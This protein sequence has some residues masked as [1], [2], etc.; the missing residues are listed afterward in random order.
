MGEDPSSGGGGVAGT[1]CNCEACTE[2]RKIECE[3]EKE[4]QELQQCWMELRHVVRCVYREAGTGMGAGGEEKRAEENT[5]SSLQV[6]DTNK[7]KD[8]VHR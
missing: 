7:M 2:R 6:P 8:L 3:H 1:Q 5:N 4:T